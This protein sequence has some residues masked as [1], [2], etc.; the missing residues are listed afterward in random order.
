MYL[1]DIFTVTANI[2]GDP[3]ISLPSGTVEVGGKS[4]PLGIQLTASQ[5]GEVILF[6][7]GKKFL[8]EV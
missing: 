3:A 6:E 4:F 1:L 2:T 8:G 7:I 5:M